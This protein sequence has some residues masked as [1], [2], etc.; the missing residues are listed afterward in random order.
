V[1]L[2]FG[3]RSGPAAGLGRL[4]KL[5]RTNSFKQSAGYEVASALAYVTPE[6]IPTPEELPLI[7]YK[8]I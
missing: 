6:H 7:I 1:V 2:R 4:V 5:Y 3:E 8:Y